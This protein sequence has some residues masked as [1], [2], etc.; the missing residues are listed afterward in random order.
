MDSGDE[1]GGT[2]TNLSGRRL[3]AGVSAIFKSG[4]QVGD[5]SLEQTSDSQITSLHRL[6]PHLSGKKKLNGFRVICKRQNLYFLRHITVI[7]P[8]RNHFKC[9]RYSSMMFSSR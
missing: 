7:L 1:S 9:L 2:V 8:M 4:Q 3:Q 6:N 5:K